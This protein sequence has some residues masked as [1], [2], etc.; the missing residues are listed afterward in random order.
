MN[1]LEQRI[2]ELVKEVG[3]NKAFD[4]FLKI[5]TG[6]M[7]RS[8]LIFYIAGENSN[9]I[10]L[11]S[12]IELI[13]LASLLHDDVIDN[14]TIRRGEASINALFGNKNAIM[15]G[16]ILYSKAFFELTKFDSAIAK[17]VSNAVCELSIGEMMDVELSNSFN[18]DKE[19]YFEMIYKKTA[20]LIE[21]ASIS[22]AIV[23]NKDIEAYRVYGKNLGLAF[24]IVDDLLDITQDEKI[25]GKPTMSDFKEGKTTLPYIFCYETIDE[26]AQ[27]KLLELY[28][29]DL[30]ET[31]KAW[32]RELLINSGAISK[33]KAIAKELGEKALKAIKKESNNKLEDIIRAMI[34]REF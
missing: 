15:L 27:Q 11:A 7:L 10:T 16:D 30:N 18:P 12:I 4:Y 22:A 33:T 6:K 1:N 31:Q 9:T 3:Y 2:K 20:S 26:K 14:A 8:K 25:L 5:P 23:S 32:I 17:V 19:L 13:H 21:A 29:Q 28:K 24:Q 34:D